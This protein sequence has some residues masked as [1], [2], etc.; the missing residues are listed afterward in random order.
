MVNAKTMANTKPMANIYLNCW[1]HYYEECLI[2][3]QLLMPINSWQQVIW[4]QKVDIQH[5]A[6]SIYNKTFAYKK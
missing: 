2:I 5:E 1:Y 6:I 3:S 4:W